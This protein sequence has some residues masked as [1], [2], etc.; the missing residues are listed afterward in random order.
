VAYDREMAEKHSRLWI[1]IDARAGASK[2]SKIYPTTVSI[3]ETLL[4]RFR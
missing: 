4:F 3:S 2:D 1:N